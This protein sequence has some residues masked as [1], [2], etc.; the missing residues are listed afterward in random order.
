MTAR[1]RRQLQ[2]VEEMVGAMVAEFEPR[3]ISPSAEIQAS[4]GLADETML[5]SVGPTR[6]IT[7]CATNDGDWSIKEFDTSS[8]TLVP[9]W[10]ETGAL[11]DSMV[12]SVVL[13]ATIGSI[14]EQLAGKGAKAV[15]AELREPLTVQLAL[16]R[17][18]HAVLSEKG[19]ESFEIEQPA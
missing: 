3:V 16:L 10:D 1:Q 13:G 18:R 7:V 12:A 11:E 5:F 19:F 15:D 9:I 17:T 14:E 6:A 2:N 4:L 8:G